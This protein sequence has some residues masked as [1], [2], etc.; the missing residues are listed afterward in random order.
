MSVGAA[1]A[2]DGATAPASI[3]RREVAAAVIGNALEFY[4]FTTYAFFASEIGAAFFPV[5]SHFISLIL[6]LAT[7]G[8]GFILRPIGSV[9]IGRYG[10]K[11]GR[12]PAM[13][14]SFTL[15]G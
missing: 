2:T 12:K 3:S 7:F 6:S 10:D 11:R 4:D 14:F 15:M 5:H 8:A 13:L 9:L 1:P